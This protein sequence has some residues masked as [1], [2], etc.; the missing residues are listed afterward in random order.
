MKVKTGVSE[1]HLPPL[2]YG[3]NRKHRSFIKLS[4]WGRSVR[5]NERTEKEW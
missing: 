4:R 5:V 2:S 1:A 3:F